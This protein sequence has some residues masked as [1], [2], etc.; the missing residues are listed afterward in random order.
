MKKRATASVKKLVKY[1]DR[2]LLVDSLTM[3]LRK[4]NPRMVWIQCSGKRR[5]EYFIYD[6]LFPLLF[7]GNRERQRKRT[8]LLI[9]FS[10]SR[11]FVGV[12]TEHLDAPFQWLKTNLSNDPG[13][14]KSTIQRLRSDG[15]HLN[16]SSKSKFRT[17]AEKESIIYVHF[18]DFDDLKD[19]L[20]SEGIPS[21]Y[22]LISDMGPK[23][24]FVHHDH[25]HRSRGRYFQIGVWVKGRD[26][27]AI[28]KVINILGPVYDALYPPP[29]MKL[30]REGNFRRS[31]QVLYNKNAVSPLCGHLGCR[32]KGFDKLQAAHI[33]AVRDGGADTPRNG[34]FLCHTHHKK[35]ERASLAAYRRAIKAKYKRHTRL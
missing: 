7:R 34:I 2:D 30:L 8:G 17:S 9:E 15:I 10:G 32:V 13:I 4:A 20:A 21:I 24:K 29:E 35:L 28:K 1:T 3:Q 25:V 27:K 16:W 6:S 12:S 19:A 33:V 18:D 26:P 31:L 14:L 11:T 23:M 5:N 22:D